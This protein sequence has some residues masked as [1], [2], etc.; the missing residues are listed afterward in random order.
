[1]VYLGSGYL[2]EVRTLK[3]IGWLD[4]YPAFFDV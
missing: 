2:A 1:V 4:A 3:Q